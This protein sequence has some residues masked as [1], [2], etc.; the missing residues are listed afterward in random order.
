MKVLF[1]YF[2]K[3]INMNAFYSIITSENILTELSS[4][5]VMPTHF[6]EL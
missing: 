4:H 5:L 2:W 1:Y 6:H 3:P